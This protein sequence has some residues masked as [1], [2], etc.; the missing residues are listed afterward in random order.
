MVKVFRRIFAIMLIA[1]WAIYA[2]LN[3]G[4]RLPY[5]QR[6]YADGWDMGSRL[7]GVV[8]A[9]NAGVLY[10][11]A[12]QNANG[13]MA[14]LLN[15]R[16][17]NDFRLLRADD[18]QYAYSSCYTY[19]NY[20]YAQQGLQFKEILAA[21]EKQQATLLYVNC[22]DLYTEENEPVYGSF[23]MADLNPRADAFLYS[24]QGYG[25]EYLDSRIVLRDSGLPKA[26]YRYKTEP[27][28]TIEACFEIYQAL[29]EKLQAQGVEIDPKGIFTN[30]KQFTKET[31]TGYIG[32]LGKMVGLTYAES[33][34]F[35][36][37]Q[38]NFETNFVLEYPFAKTGKARIK[39]GTFSETLLDR[40]WL[41]NDYAYEKNAYNAYLTTEY[42]YRIIKNENNID[43]P[44]ILVIG[45]SYMLPVTTFLAT[46][47][48]EIHLLWP[49]GLPEGED[50][51][52]FLANND[53]DSIIIG[54]SPNSLSGS[55]FNYLNDID[56]S[57]ED[58]VQ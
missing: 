10:Q 55:G 22:L 25:I 39:T 38:P 30:E 41:E 19:E 36:L 33:E 54:M 7:Q 16:A 50:L 1:V 29:V 26:Q 31:L 56:V 48:S 42:D 12:L 8:N 37:I 45:D 21:A 53:F 46:A 40:Y 57:L 18:G 44:K 2:I 13:H 5:L 58:I 6:G 28:W 52:T 51:L 14:K 32:E 3:F 20:N 23:P 11:D 35:T 27:H 9:A 4:A 15:K 49:Y 47:A 43:G 17:L 24:L 34:S